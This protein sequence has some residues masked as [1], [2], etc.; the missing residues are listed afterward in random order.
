M[1]VTYR[2][3]NPVRLEELGKVLDDVENDK[4]RAW[5]ND[6]SNHP[7]RGAAPTRHQYG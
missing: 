1:I 5:V 4:I 6:E 3:G 7:A 2:N